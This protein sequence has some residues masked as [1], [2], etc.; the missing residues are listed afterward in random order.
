MGWFYVPRRPFGGLRRGSI[1]VIPLERGGAGAC[2]QD[3]YG[4]PT[5]ELYHLSSATY[6]F[7]VAV[8]ERRAYDDRHRQ[9]WRDEE[10][11]PEQRVPEPE[12]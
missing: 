4:A 1:G 6:C 3:W 8:H 12:P 7:D 11:G 2:C 5:E 9:R 10:L